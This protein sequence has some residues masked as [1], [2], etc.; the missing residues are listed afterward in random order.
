MSSTKENIKHLTDWF[1]SNDWK[2]HAFQKKAWKHQLEGY[3]GIVNAPTGSGKTYSVLLP[4]FAPYINKKEKAKGLKLIWIAPIRALA[5]EICISAERAIEAFGLDWKVGIRTGDTKTTERQKQITT[6]PQILITTPESLHIILTSKKSKKILEGCYNLVVDEWHELIGS[7]RGVQT[8]LFLGYMRALY[9]KIKIWG[10]SAT[11][12]N[13]SEAMDVLLGPDD[14]G[15]R[16]LIKAKIK[17][18]IIVKT[19]M[20]KEIERYPWSGHLGILLL[21]KVIPIIENSGSTLIFT[22]TRA[23]CEIWYQKLLAEDPSLAGIMA[24]HHGSLSREM[25]TWVEEALYTGK[26]KAVVCTSSLDL[27]V[28]F[29]P[30]DN[31][32]QVGSPKGVAR[33]VQRAGRSGHRPG[34]TSKIYFLPTNSLELIE[35]SALRKAIKENKIENRVP[36][37]RSWDVLVQYMMTRAV[38]GGFKEKELY[39]EVVATHCY[40]TMSREEWSLLLNHLLYGSQSL[41]AYD[42]YQKIGKTSDGTYL[43]NNRGVAQR[44]RLSIGTI[45]SDAM[46]QVKF[47]RGRK[48]GMVEEWFIGQFSPGDTF[49]FAGMALE[50]VRIKDNALQVKK[51]TKKTGRIPSYMGGRL[52][53]TS[54]MSDVIKEK[55]FEYGKG[56]VK[57]AEMKKLMPLFD[58]QE[59]RSRMPREEELLIEYFRSNEGFH[60]LMYPFEGRDIHEGMAALLGQRLSKILPISFSLAYNDFGLELLSDKQ[61]DVDKILNKELFNPRNLEQDIQ[62]S[63]NAVELAQRKFRDIAC[64]SG[65]VFTG[66]PGKEKKQRHLVS[67]SRLL[68]DVFREYEPENLLYLQTFDEVMAVQLKEVRMREALERIQKQKLVITKPEKYTPFS[69]PI[70]VDRLREKMSS[71]TLLDRIEKMKVELVK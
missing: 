59:L 45:V 66:Y 13:L 55:I 67:N 36:F 26:L 58:L 57:D 38:G 22:N 61:I 39:D 25:R 33:F 32:V 43:V 48:V 56:E 44:H 62:S 51:S 40:Q 6:P 11:I 16:I 34:A 41:K 3:S 8:E 69:F 10:I 46:L 42:E 49:W 9:P 15:K 12:G 2:A 63:I 5:K 4:V 70:M 54:Q 60:L 65:L 1:A 52:S 19:I 24:M 18:K 47:V 17:K 20:P 64:I 31:I 14:G 68:F 28:D 30:V 7:K 37:E 50:Y 23:Q 71:E 29:R 35:S 53:F 27:G 21:K